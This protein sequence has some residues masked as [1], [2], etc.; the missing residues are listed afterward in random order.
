MSSPLLNTSNMHRFVRYDAR[1]EILESI[2]DVADIELFG[3]Q[4]I[5][6]PYVHSGLLWNRTMGFP[7][8]ER[9]SLDR[10]YELFAGNKGFVT[11]TESKESIYSGKVMLVVKT[12]ED[13]EKVRVGEWAFTLQE[14]TRQVSIQTP[15]SRPSRVLK[16]VGLDYVAGW[17]CKFV[18]ESDIYG[19]IPYPDMVV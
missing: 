2:G 7:I 9:L 6:A 1:R 10:L 5:C 8:E 17:P 4:V 15:T 14:N 16:F 12:G 13:V 3:T 18:Y 11:Q 19:R